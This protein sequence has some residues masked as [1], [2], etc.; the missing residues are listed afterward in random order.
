MT[1]TVVAGAIAL[2]SASCGSSSHQA[3]QEAPALTAP[4]FPAEVQ[5][6]VEAALGVETEVLVYGNLSKTGHQ[7]ALAVNR[8]KVTPERAAPGI[9]VT[10]TVV[11]EN[12]EGTWKEIFLCDEH[13][14]N[15]SGYL[16]ATPLAPVNGW[17]LQFKQDS[18]KG[19]QMYFTPLALPRGESIIAIGVRW[20][21]RVKRYQSL[22][23]SFQQFLG[24]LPALETPESQVR[25]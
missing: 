24:E 14:K 12:D 4:A 1:F 20:N 25:L 23:K 19:L 10:R 17:R 16:E 3:K 6:A 11:I 21:P 15:P 22:D 9:L 8:L 7:Q 13:L 18:E 2:T 5:S